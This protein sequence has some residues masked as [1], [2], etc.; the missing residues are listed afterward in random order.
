VADASTF[1]AVVDE[2]YALPPAEFVAA[3]E[4]HAKAARSGGDRGLAARIHA[5]R[6]PTVGAW[7]VN[8]LARE[9]PELLRQL[10]DLGGELRAAQEGLRGEDLRALSSQ[11][12]QVVSALVGE[13]RRL[14]AAA[15]QRGSDEAAY[16][17][18]R[19]LLA[20]LADPDVG[21]QVATGALVKPL[22]YSGFGPVGSVD[23]VR[24]DA[25]P[26]RVR[27]EDRPAPARARPAGGNDLTAARHRRE[28]AEAEAALREAEAERRQAAGR[29]KHAAER[30][31][32][33]ESRR[34][35]AD[36]E[37]GRLSRELHAAQ[38]VA[39]A[40]QDLER[41]ARAKASAAAAEAEEAAARH[42]AARR[43]L[44]ELPG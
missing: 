8:L 7:M 18:E 22:D 41:H 19:T 17:V 25:A 15:G 31:A 34:Q 24:R 16:E 28:R 5:L 42:T 35:E 40:A 11:R 1:D 26:R 3:R 43:R 10:V 39:T 32:D 2:L 4:G 12:Q 23:V 13:A 14:S 27:R 29:A 20:A 33:A 36:A 44:D 6:R 9:R 38:S 30:A 21:E 37:I